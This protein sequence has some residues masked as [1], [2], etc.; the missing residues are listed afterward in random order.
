MTYSGKT[1]TNGRVREITTLV[2]KDDAIS[3]EKWLDLQIEKE[4][5]NNLE[6]KKVFAEHPER[7]EMYK[8]KLIDSEPSINGGF[9][10]RYREEMK[11]K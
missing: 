6:L 9:Y 5:A 4:L 10:E 1:R 7:R 11:N 3:F 2:R 8:Q